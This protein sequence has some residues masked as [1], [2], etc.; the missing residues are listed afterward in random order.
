MKSCHKVSQKEIIFW[1]KEQLCK[2]GLPADLDWLLDMGGGVRLST[3]NYLQ[4]KS[5]DFVYIE[6][7]LDEL[8]NFWNQHIE[9]HFP[10]QYLVGVCH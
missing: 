5:S 2:G 9:D 10:L 3:L 7:P 8:E 1:R 4:P 6:K